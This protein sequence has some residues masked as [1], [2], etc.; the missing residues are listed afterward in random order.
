[1]VP[2]RIPHR[3]RVVANIIMMNRHQRMALT[4]SIDGKTSPDIADIAITIIIIG[5]IIPA[6]TAA[7]PNMRPPKIGRAHV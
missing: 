7:S 6:E 5:E 4:S 2:N 3:P 1:M